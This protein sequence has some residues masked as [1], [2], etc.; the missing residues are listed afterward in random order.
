LEKASQRFDFESQ[1][2]RPSQDA[3]LSSSS[4]GHKPEDP[5]IHPPGG[6]FGPS[7]DPSVAENTDMQ[8]DDDYEAS[9]PLFFDLDPFQVAVDVD[10]NDQ[11]KSTEPAG[12][13]A[14]LSEI[15]PEIVSMVQGYVEFID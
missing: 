14:W 11:N 2:E 4:S 1:E 8:T 10:E 7:V 5:R 6:W 9:D 15:D 12:E 13:P 3:Q